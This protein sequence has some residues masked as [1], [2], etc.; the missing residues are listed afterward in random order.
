MEPFIGGARVFF[1][2]KNHKS[3]ELDFIKGIDKNKVI[4]IKKDQD[5][6]T[7]L[8]EASSYK[9]ESKIVLSEFKFRQYLDGIQNG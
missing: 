9:E 2:L 1:G 5:F 8:K 6:Y 7:S 4:E 3:T